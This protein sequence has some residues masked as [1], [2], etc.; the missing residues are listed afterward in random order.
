VLVAP[1]RRPHPLA[2]D[3]LLVAHDGELAGRVGADGLRDAVKA[4]RP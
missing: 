1:G 3:A 4:L 2:K